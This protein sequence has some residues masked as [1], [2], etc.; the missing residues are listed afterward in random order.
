MSYDV[1]VGIHSRVLSQR[2]SGCHAYGAR[3]DSIITAT[4]ILMTRMFMLS[5]TPAA[6]LPLVRSGY[7]SSLRVVEILAGAIVARS[8]AGVKPIL[9]LAF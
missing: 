8:A 4:P 1:G 3:D 5:S 6:R 9:C 2:P 7:A